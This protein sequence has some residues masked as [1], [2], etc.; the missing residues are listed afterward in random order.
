MRARNES[1]HDRQRGDPHRRD[2]RA[3]RTHEVPLTRQFRAR[4]NS[5]RHAMVHVVGTSTRNRISCEKSS[6]RSEGRSSPRSPPIPSRTR[7]TRPARSAVSAGAAM[8]RT[9]A[10]RRGPPTLWR[11]LHL[12]TVVAGASCPGGNAHTVT[13]R[14]AP[15]VRAPGTR[16]SQPLDRCAT[17][18]AHPNRCATLA[19][20]PSLLP[21][22]QP[23]GSGV[24]PLPAGRPA[25]PWSHR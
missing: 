2:R 16:I 10:A 21:A 5:A 14:I 19:T 4:M 23:L 20:H 8:P 1:R 15:V 24:K 3:C 7:G 18:A 12:P 6:R 9:A 17:L 11:P 25:L 13:S 22:L